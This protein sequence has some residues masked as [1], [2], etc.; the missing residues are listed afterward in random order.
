[1][2]KLIICTF[3]GLFL[4]ANYSFAQCTHA[5]KSAEA[6]TCVKPSEAALKAAAKD[7]NIETKVCEN[8]GSVCFK[9]KSVAAD[10]TASV[11]DVRYDETTASFVAIPSASGA[12]KKS[13]SS[14]KACC[15]K[16]SASGKACCKAKSSASVPTENA[17]PAKS[18]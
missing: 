11:E 14:S 4:S 8:S 2:K 7:P 15:A 5:S 17:A 16:G 18:E 9:R 10:G 3:L 12:E 6:K 13:C 1:M